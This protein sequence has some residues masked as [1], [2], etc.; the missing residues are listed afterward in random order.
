[1][2]LALEIATYISCNSLIISATMVT[3]FISFLTDKQAVSG[4]SIST[5]QALARDNLDYISNLE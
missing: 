4:T 1:M 2:K 3:R 5:F